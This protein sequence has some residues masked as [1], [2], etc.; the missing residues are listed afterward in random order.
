[1]PTPEASAT[2]LAHVAAPGSSHMLSVYGKPVT[3]RHLILMAALLLILMSMLAAGATW[4]AWQNL[5]A[6]VVLKEQQADILLPKSLAVEASVDRKVQIQVDQTLPVRVP[7]HQMLSIPLA[8]AIPIQVSVDTIVPIQIDVPVQHVIKVDQIV[9]IDTQVKT[10]LLGIPVTLPIQGRIPV[11]A[12]VP[13]DLIIPVRKQLPVA[14]VTVATVHLSEPL[15]TQ[16][17]TVV[18]T[19]VPIHEAMSVPLTAPV[20]ALL[21]FPQQHVQAGINLLDLTVPFQSVTLAPRGSAPS[22]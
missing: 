13:I 18:E 15:R 5:A 20:S 6:Q 22:R 9:D 11:K 14:L 19:R 17:D 4:W 1:M 7:I 16:I 3:W 21:T 2:P 8:Q 12:D 10:R